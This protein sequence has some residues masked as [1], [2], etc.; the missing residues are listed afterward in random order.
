MFKICLYAFIIGREMNNVSGEWFT[1]DYILA[2]LT[3]AQGIRQHTQPHLLQTSPKPPQNKP[4][5]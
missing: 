3:V 2:G 1:E 5:D 4:L